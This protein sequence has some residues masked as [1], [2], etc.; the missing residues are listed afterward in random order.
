MRQIPI[1]PLKRKCSG[2]GDIMTITKSDYH[3]N[4]ILFDGKLYHKDCYFKTKTITK[5]CYECKRNILFPPITATL[6]QPDSVF[7]NNHFYHTKC[8]IK[9]CH[10]TV[11]KNKMRMIALDNIDIYRK[12]AS[13]CVQE[14]F[15]NKK[16]DATSIKKFIEDANTYIMNW[17]DGAELT[18][19]LK[20]MYNIPGI[21]QFTWSK[22]K[23]SGIPLSDLLYMWKRRKE[24]LYK[25]NQ[26]LITQNNNHMRTESLIRYDLQVLINKYGS[27]LKWKEQQKILEN[28]KESEKSNI[29]D[30][31]IINEIISARQHNEK[32]DTDTSE[33]GVDINALVDD[34]F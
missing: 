10:S 24:D 13:D 6:T 7:Y 29:K 9:W 20:D 30:N 25:L 4:Y 34:I 28:E 27:Y 14:T 11:R 18:V 22:I 3:N 2:C 17:F 32:P 12:N 19:F 8:F 1:Q 15:I 21:D 23:D 16:Q 31:H 26:K 5:K 33:G